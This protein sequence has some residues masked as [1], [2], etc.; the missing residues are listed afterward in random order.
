MRN[1]PWKKIIM[2]TLWI[3]LGVAAMVFFVMA[4][5]E[6]DKKRIKDIQIQIAGEEELAVMEGNVLTETLVVCVLEQPNALVPVTV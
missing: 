4:W 6:K 2:R 1:L 5:R 3:M